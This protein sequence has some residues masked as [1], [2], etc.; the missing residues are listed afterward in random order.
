MYFLKV[1][2]LPSHDD[3]PID[4]SPSLCGAQ[5]LKVPWGVMGRSLWHGVGGAVVLRGCKNDLSVLPYPITVTSIN[6]QRLL[7]RYSF[8][9]YVVKF[10]CYCFQFYGKKQG[11]MV[12]SMIICDN[13]Y[14]VYIHD[15]NGSYVQH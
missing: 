11:S 6:Y 13:F 14:C 8:S 7:I 9:V 5:Q 4:R 15:F 2:C 10:E 12:S 3:G 1:K